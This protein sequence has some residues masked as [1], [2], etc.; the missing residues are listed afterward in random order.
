MKLTDILGGSLLDGVK[1]IIG[2]FKLSPEKK[3]ELQATV[4]AHAHELA[5]KQAELEARIAEFQ[6]REIEAASANI[7]AE[8][9][10]GD[11]FTSRAR[12]TFL[13]ISNVILL[14]NYILFPLLQRPP[15]DFPEPLFW[16]FGSVMLGY[17]GARSWEKL[18]GRTK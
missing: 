2:Q 11:K 14:F 8:A 7:R 4:E 15:L 17:T 10:S 9:A 16:L 18:A 1:G 13:Y 12:P 6:A 5:V 3:A